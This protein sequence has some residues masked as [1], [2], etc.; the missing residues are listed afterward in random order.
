MM[1]RVARAL[2]AEV[3]VVFEAAHDRKHA[4]VAEFSARYGD[5]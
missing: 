1:R 3:K 2:N 5:R 4:V